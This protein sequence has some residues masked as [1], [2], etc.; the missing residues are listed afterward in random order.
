VQN[1]GIRDFYLC[2]SKEIFKEVNMKKSLILVLASS[3]AIVGCASSPKARKAVAE[4]PLQTEGYA[5]VYINSGENGMIK[6]WSDQQ[7]GPV[8]FNGHTVGSTAKNEY[9][10]IDILPGTY[11]TQCTTHKSYKN[12]EE[13][14]SY[15]FK[16]GETRYFACEQEQ[17][18]AGAYFGAIGAI[19]SEFITKTFLDEKRKLEKATLVEYKKIEKNMT[20]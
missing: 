3:M 17:E 5:R 6:L 20:K 18:G 11:E 10:V 14:L 19:A 16:A 7:V 1:G 12:K 4:L 8:L 15:T 13:E 9:F 2:K